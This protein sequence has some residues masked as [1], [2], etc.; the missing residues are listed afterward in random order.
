M[1]AHD[2]DDESFSS[3]MRKTYDWWNVAER[4]HNSVPC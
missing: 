4:A 1:N 3:Q 2:R